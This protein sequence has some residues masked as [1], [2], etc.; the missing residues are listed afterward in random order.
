[1]DTR[2]SCRFLRRL[3]PTNSCLM[4]CHGTIS[5]RTISALLMILKRDGFIIPVLSCLDAD[6]LL[7]ALAKSGVNCYTLVSII[8][9]AL[10]DAE[11]LVLIC[12]T[13]FA[14]RVLLH[15][16]DRFATLYD[17]EFSVSKLKF[18]VIV[19]KSMQLI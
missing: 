5:C 10:A 3:G 2:S 12:L 15:L 9:S 7:F 18:F 4:N 11:D 19:F 16:F 6:D 17:N 14:I 1:M 8:T 13:P